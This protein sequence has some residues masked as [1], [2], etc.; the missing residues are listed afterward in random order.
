VRRALIGIVVTGVLATV[1]SG[2]V[3]PLTASQTPAYIPPRTPGGKPD[4]NGIWQALNTANYDLL[5]HSA[6]PAMALRAGPAGPIP[7]ASVLP[8]GAVGAVPA[9]LGVVE[10]DE[11]P[12]Q[13]WAAAKQ[14][15]NADNWV[16]SDPEIKCYLPGVPRATYMP[17]P[18]QI[19]QNDRFILIAYEYASAVRNVYMADPGPPPIDSWM[20]QSVGRWDGDTLVITVTGFNGQAWFD[21]AGNFASEALRVVERYTRTGPDHLTYEATIEDPKV[22]TR[23]WKISMPLYRRVE[24]NARLHEFK[25][26]EFVEELMYGH[27]R[28]KPIP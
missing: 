7:A 16:T 12:Y 10:G 25:C 3:A 20:G 26:V 2:I 18:F 11:I 24:K 17:F 19:V 5:S 13:P 4:L 9:G 23:P 22:F 8:L 15:E 21:R 28:K 6:R 14:K 27:L 1:V